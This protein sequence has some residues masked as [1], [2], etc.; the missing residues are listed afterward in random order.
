MTEQYL[1]TNINSPNGNLYYVDDFIG[2]DDA[3][4]TR[5]SITTAGSGTTLSGKWLGQ[6][7][8]NHPGNQELS[9][10]TAIGDVIL[11]QTMQTTARGMRLEAIL[12]FS[13]GINDP[14]TNEVIFTFGYNLPTDGNGMFFLYDPTSANWQAVLRL[15]G[16]NTVIDTGVVVEA[17]TGYK[18]AIVANEEAN[19]GAGAVQFVIDG[20]IVATFDQSTVGTSLDISIRLERT[21]ASA[22]STIVSVDR[23]VAQQ[24]I[25]R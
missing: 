7:P 10:S 21:F 23:V 19:E 9:V 16:S 5:W 11:E 13:T 6:D 22:N 4:N 3:G 12:A 1:P 2:G 14:G 8:I 17:S 20:T 24:A 25:E 15:G 18:L